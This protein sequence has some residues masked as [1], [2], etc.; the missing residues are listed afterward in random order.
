MKHIVLIGG[1]GT[2]GKELCEAWH[3]TFHLTVIDLH[4]P[5]TNVNVNYIK[6][7][8]TKREQLRKHIPKSADVIANLLKFEP[9]DEVEAL[10]QMTEVYF[11]ASVYIYETAIELGVPKVIFASS[12][13][14]T[15][16]YEHE[17]KSLIGRE[18]SVQD[19]PLSRNLYGILKLA[20]ENTGHMYASKTPLSVINL[21]IGTVPE[22]EL[23]KLKEDQR[24]HFTLLTREDLVQLFTAAVE[25]SKK[26]GTFYGVSSNDNKPWDMKEAYEELGYHS[27]NNAKDL[28]KQ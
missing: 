10:D 24:V 19:Y 28:L 2:I 17:G 6:M 3:G 12:N 21:R 14:V 11:K 13:H 22:D 26:Y 7:D 15:N 1:S 5:E 9:K 18:I 25:S 27:I 23:K 16:F 4:P 20:S 8:A